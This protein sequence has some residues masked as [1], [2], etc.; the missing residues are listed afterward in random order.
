MLWT[1]KAPALAPR[2]LVTPLP[3]KLPI[4]LHP[5]CVLALLPQNDP[6]WFDHSSRGNHGIV[7]GATPTAK[8]PD[9]FAWELGGVDDWINCGNDTSL[10]ITDAITIVA[11]IKPAA[12]ITTFQRIVGNEMAGDGLSFGVSSINN[13][14]IH[15]SGSINFSTTNNPLSVGIW[16][17]CAMSFDKDAGINNGK[18]YLKG[19]LVKTGT[20]PNPIPLNTHVR[21]IGAKPDGTLLFR[22]LI[23]YVLIYNHAW[24]PR[25]ADANYLP[26]IDPFLGSF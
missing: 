2:P 25:P 4:S 19:A 5:S 3:R 13:L 6:K 11:R 12:T 20:N 17:Q 24:S 10:R 18:I 21:A 23:D 14:D 9:G 16:Q 22:G 15:T 26:E 8:G 7:H 1:P